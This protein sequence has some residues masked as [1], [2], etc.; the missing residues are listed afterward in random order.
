MR[1]AGRVGSLV[2]L[3]VPAFAPGCMT[4]ARVANLEDAS[5]RDTLGNAI[6]T[7]LVGQHE[8]AEIADRLARDVVSAAVPE[9]RPPPPFRVSSPSGTDYIFLLQRREKGCLLRLWGRQTDSSSY[10]NDLTYIATE[11][12]PGC[13][14]SSE[15]SVVER[16]GV[17]GSGRILG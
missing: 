2:W 4:I 11:P 15:V 9:V 13:V 7:I 3:V 17:R 10:I 5:C 12:L 16:R 6:S 1:L 8:R 14:C